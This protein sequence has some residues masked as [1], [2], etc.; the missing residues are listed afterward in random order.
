MFGLLYL[1]DIFPRQLI[2]PVKPFKRSSSMSSFYKVNRL[3]LFE[4]KY[5]L[6]FYINKRLLFNSKNQ[7]SVIIFLCVGNSSLYF[8]FATK[9]LAILKKKC[10]LFQK[11]TLGIVTYSYITIFL[12]IFHEMM[13][14]SKAWTNLFI[15][16]QFN[17]IFFV[18]T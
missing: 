5:Y 15:F 7:S 10:M 12:M 11:L 18:R 4:N 6:W 1:N 2:N 13:T 9:C 16:D 8:T 17:P 3:Q 14:K